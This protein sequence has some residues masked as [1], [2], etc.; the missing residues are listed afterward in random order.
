MIATSLSEHVEEDT[1]LQVRLKAFSKILTYIVVSATLIIFIVGLLMG[2]WLFGNAAHFDHPGDCRGARRTAD[3]RDSD[4][5]T[6]DAQDSEAKRAGEA[7]SGG[8]DAG[9]GDGDLHRQDRHTNR[10]KDT[11]QS[12]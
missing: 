5:G 1:P 12:G 4:P 10:G 11:G 6:G 8:R 2:R 7:A 9:L 3:R